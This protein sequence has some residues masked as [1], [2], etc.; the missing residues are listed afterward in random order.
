MY[1]YAHVVDLCMN[2]NISFKMLA[3]CNNILPEKDRGRENERIVVLRIWLYS[4][5]IIWECAE[6]G[7]IHRQIKNILHL[8]AIFLQSANESVFAIHRL[9]SPFD[10]MGH[11]LV[12]HPREFLIPILS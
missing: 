6:I 1:V 11:V 7:I 12:N 8:H 10:D 3:C 9:L 4:Y 2:V 5:M